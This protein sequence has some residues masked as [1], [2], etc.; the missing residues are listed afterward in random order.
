MYIRRTK[1]KTLSENEAYYTYRI[2]ESMRLGK[3]VKQRTLLNLG[4]EFPIAS[5]H[6]PLLCAHIEQL[7]QNETSAQVEI[8]NLA[9]ELSQT[10][11]AAAQ[12]YYALI[13]NKHAQPI[14]PD[15]LS[16]HITDYHSIDINRVEALQARSIGAETLALHALQQLQLDQKLTALGFN[17]VDLAAAI[18]SIIARM[19]SPGSERHTH[20]WLNHQ[21]CL[22]E[23]IDVDYS[24]ISLTRLYKVSDKLL[25]HQAMLES[26]LATQEQTLFNLPR[27]II[28]VDLTNTYFE[29]R[30]HL[31]PQAQFGRSKEK[32]RD[33]PLVTLG[34]VL[35]SDGFPL[36]SQ[37]FPGSASE[38]ATLETML[39][40]LQ[41]KRGQTDDKPI[42]ILD[43]GIATADN[44][45]WLKEQNYYYLVVSRER[46]KLDPR[47]QDDAVLIREHNHRQVTIFS[48]ID[49]E[50]KE[51]RIYC[52]SE[53]K[54]K[55]A[56]V[57]Q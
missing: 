2:V 28:L 46:H 25:S 27:Q 13:L 19:V 34:L 40:G 1:T 5:E 14:I 26:F 52:H 53:Q 24:K 37:V 38:P 6:W 17:G 20:R 32:R 43:T 41:Q 9:D 35:D 48:E 45:S 10:L 51:T 22:G 31:N 36:T 42:I 7:L 49:P 30:A 21:S 23:L 55:K 39:E 44:I 16:D 18:G 12:R 47:E 33:Y 29:E 8:F 56:G 50:T 3:R 15:E 4:K 11:E 57:I 54:A